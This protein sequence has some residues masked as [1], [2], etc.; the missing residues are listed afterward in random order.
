MEFAQRYP[1]WLTLIKRSG[2]RNVFKHQ[3]TFEKTM[4]WPDCGSVASTAPVTVDFPGTR[5]VIRPT[6]ST[7]ATVAFLML[8]NVVTWGY[9]PPVAFSW[10]VAP[11]TRI[12]YLGSSLKGGN[13][14]KDW[15]IY[16]ARTTE[17][18]TWLDCFSTK[19]RQ[20]MAEQRWRRTMTESW[21]Q[22][23][24]ELIWLFQSL[25]ARWQAN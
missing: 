24:T 6:L 25:S 18:Y 11:G 4:V 10:N 21:S 5:A 9:G 1:V 7:D 2:Y 17:L 19:T 8:N 20:K 13:T 16:W 22:F 3:L 12:I 14:Y 15:E 23:E